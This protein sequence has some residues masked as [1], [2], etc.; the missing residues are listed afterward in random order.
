MD[1]AEETL[2]AVRALLQFSGRCYA[3]SLSLQRTIDW[4]MAYPPEG[5]KVL[6]RDEVDNMI[7]A[8]REDADQVSQMQLSRIEP[9]IAPGS[10]WQP[11]VHSYIRAISKPE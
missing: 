2:K 8:A 5:R 1:E 9:P 10:P 4:I 7:T 6:T 3:R 11:S